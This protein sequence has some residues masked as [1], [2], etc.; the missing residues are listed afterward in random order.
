MTIEHINPPSVN[1]PL[2]QFSQVSR[3]GNVLYIAGQIAT[4]KD[5]EL[6]GVGDAEKQFN[7]TFKNVHAILKHFGADWENVVKLNT[8]FVHQMYR[9]AFVKMRNKHL[10]PPYPAQTVL[11]ISALAEPEYICEIDAIAVLE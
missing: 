5:K 9:P 7:Q 3:A 10:K 11:V 6:L 1:P 2:T 4:D 8:Y